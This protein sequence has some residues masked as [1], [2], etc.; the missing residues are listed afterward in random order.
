M[1]YPLIDRQLLADLRLV[2]AFYNTGMLLLFFYHGRLGLAIRRARNAAEKPPLPAIRRHRKMGPVLA[3]MGVCG[4]FIGLT[5]VLLRTGNVLEYPP[6]LFTG[7]AI[8]MLLAGTWAISRK[9]KGPDSPYRKP[10]YIMGVAILCLYVA[11][12][13]L[14]I[15]VLL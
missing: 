3:V 13:F 12:V 11:E 10:H 7:L 14:G 15:G 6:H 8:V 4:F 9:I 2:H 1:E 5:L